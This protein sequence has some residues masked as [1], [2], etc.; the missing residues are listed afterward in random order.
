M[1]WQELIGPQLSSFLICN[2]SIF[3]PYDSLVLYLSSNLLLS[4]C[5]LKIPSPIPNHSYC[6]ILILLFSHLTHSFSHLTHPILFL[7]Q[8][9]FF[10]LFSAMTHAMHCCIPSYPHDSFLD[11]DLLLT[12]SLS[13]FIFFFL[14][15][16]PS[17]QFT[18][19]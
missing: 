14:D 1:T 8:S 15:D 2:I 18:I 16:K 13:P 10:L 17:T 5:F 9:H 11:C 3:T 4:N 7:I 12:H 6:S 19:V